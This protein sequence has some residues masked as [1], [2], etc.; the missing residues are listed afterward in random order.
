VVGQAADIFS[1]VN[2]HRD[3]RVT[4]TNRDLC[5]HAVPNQAGHRHY[6]KWRRNRRPVSGSCNL[7]ADGKMT[8]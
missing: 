8:E 4:A 5:K 1:R 3:L 2:R 7:I 6:V